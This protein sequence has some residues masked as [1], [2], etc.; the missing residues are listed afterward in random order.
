M[1]RASN[2]LSLVGLHGGWC[3]RDPNLNLH[4]M[5]SKKKSRQDSASSTELNRVARYV[6]FLIIS[7]CDKEK[8]L[9]LSP[10]AVQKELKSIVE[11]H[12]SLNSCRGVISEIQLQNT[13]ENEILEGLSDQNV[14][15]VR[16]IILRKSSDIISTKHLILTFSGTNLPDS[17]KAGYL[18]C[19]LQKIK[20]IPLWPPSFGKPP[21]F[22]VSNPVSV[23]VSNS[24]KSKANAE[25]VT[26]DNR[27]LPSAATTEPEP[28]TTDN[29]SIHSS[30]NETE[31]DNA[32]EFNHRETIDETPPVLQQQPSISTTVAD[33]TSFKQRVKKCP[34]RW[35]DFKEFYNEQEL[36]EKISKFYTSSR[37][38]VLNTVPTKDNICTHQSALKPFETAKLNSV[39]TQFLPMAV[40]PPLEKQLSQSRK[41][42]ADAEMSS[43]SS[44]EDALEYDMSEDLEDSPAVI[45]PPP[46]SKPEKANKYKNR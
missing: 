7:A 42:D 20:P 28:M 21:L 32:I 34:V 12:R 38:E 16:R 31:S 15:H 46:S 45:S 9:C 33:K 43:S 30:D 19:K 27:T 39:D 3:R 23:Q 25:G 2:C 36:T 37:R 10:F 29:V 17:I 26:V 35:V 22:Q 6:R 41:S 14:I 44:E 18:R 4:C 1:P 13:P 8:G 5:G 24:P 40:L 11:S